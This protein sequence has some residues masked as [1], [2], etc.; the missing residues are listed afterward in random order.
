MGKNT[1]VMVDL[2]GE[3]LYR[4]VRV[5][6]ID[7]NASVSDIVCQA[8]KDWLVKEEEKEDLEAYREVKDEPSRPLDEFLE[9][10]AFRVD[11]GN[12]RVLYHINRQKKEVTVFRVRHRK[13]VYRGL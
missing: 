4:A 5:A 8:I 7:R 11:S 6:A 12:Y 10:D 1:R 2:K 3:E 9:E 13:D